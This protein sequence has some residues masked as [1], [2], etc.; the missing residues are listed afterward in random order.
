MNRLAKDQL[1]DSIVCFWCNFLMYK[2][3]IESEN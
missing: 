2:V 1:V 3:G